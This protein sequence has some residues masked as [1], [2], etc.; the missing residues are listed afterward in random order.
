MS[1]VVPH[2]TVSNERQAMSGDAPGLRDVYVARRR[3]APHVRRTPFIQ[4]DWLSSLAGGSVYLKLESLQVTNSFKARGAVNAALALAAASPGGRLP[5][6]VTASAGNAGRAL[7]YAAARF[8]FRAI[9]FTPR[10]A[11]RTKL[12]AIRGLG[13]DLRAEAGNYE[14]AEQLAK[15]FAAAS[16]LTYLSPYSHPDVIAGAATVAVEILEDMPDVDAIVVPVGGGGLLGGIAIAAK[17]ILPGVEVVGVEAEASPA[18]STSL[19]AGR[20]TEVA[21]RPTIADGLAG[22]MDPDTMTFDIV[23]RLVDRVEVANESS[24]ADAVRGMVAHEHLVT[25]GAGAAAVAGLLAGRVAAAG[26]RVAVVVSG[27]NID[28]TRLSALLHVG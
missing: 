26:R 5:V 8:G 17:T 25:E 27:S 13:A 11:P 7:A 28:A 19:R 16:G 2:S 22:N 18:F 6:L 4:S 9:V 23:R 3:I 12:D 21:V 1:L 20:I 10:D 14:E 24:L 15:R